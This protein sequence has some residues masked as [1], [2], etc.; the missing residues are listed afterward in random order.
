MS[1]PTLFPCLPVFMSQKTAEIDIL[2][3]TLQGHKLLSYIIKHSAWYKDSLKAEKNIIV[4]EGF[5]YFF[6]FFVIKDKEVI[7]YYGLYLNII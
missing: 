6:V 5:T 4:S 1:F 7:M 3:H 2:G